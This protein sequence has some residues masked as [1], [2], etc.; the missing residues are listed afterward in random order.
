[1]AFEDS[2]MDES[3]MQ[4][5]HNT[6]NIQINRT[7]SGSEG[8]G[9]LQAQ[10][11]VW[12]ETVATDLKSSF[13]TVHTDMEKAIVAVDQKT[14]QNI[15]GLREF[16]HRTQ[17]SQQRVETEVNDLQVVLRQNVESTT[18]KLAQLT[19]H[20]Q[21]MKQSFVTDVQEQLS[22]HYAQLREEILETGKS[23]AQ[24]IAYLKDQM[25]QEQGLF[26]QSHQTVQNKQMQDLFSE[27]Q[28]IKGQVQKEEQMHQ[29]QGMFQQT[30]Q[31]QMQDLYSELQAVKGQVQK[32]EQTA[33]VLVER[34]REARQKE[35]LSLKHT[36]DRM[37]KEYVQ[38]SVVPTQPLEVPVYMMQTVTEGLST[39]GQEEQEIQPTSAAELVLPPVTNGAPAT[40]GLLPPTP[41]VPIPPGPS[42]LG[43]IDL[44]TGQSLPMGSPIPILS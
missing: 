8:G 18:E 34:E 7:E 12:R 39:E 30:Y 37:L 20:L 28:T 24:S 9:Q 32:E 36:M 26:Q 33:L 19:D 40:V 1:M 15:Q 4:V 38:A 31:K 17:E 6:Q 43:L 42:S 16:V 35:E 41:A 11:A 14:E 29:E 27:L 2:T 3:A 22:T 10:L 23:H 21:S 5:V 25:Q 13:Q 44:T